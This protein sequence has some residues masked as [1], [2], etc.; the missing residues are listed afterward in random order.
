M[1][2][3][4]LSYW[5]SI[6]KPSFK[7]IF[8]RLFFILLNFSTFVFL[9]FC[10]ILKF[11]NV[12]I[13]QGN[14]LFQDILNIF[15]LFFYIKGGGWLGSEPIV[16]NSTIFCRRQPT[17][18]LLFHSV[19]HSLTQS[20][21]F[22]SASPAYLFLFSCQVQSSQVKSSQVKSSQVWSSQVQSSP[23]K[24]SQVQS[25]Q[26]QS[27]QVKSSQVKSSQVKSST[28]K[29]SQVYSGLVKSTKIQ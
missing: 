12:S 25:S 9:H 23:V 26:V 28:F 5:L 3:K 2:G 8:F 14:F 6:P 27:I 15:C 13:R 7:S 21:F 16:E 24:S 1:I 22:K 18:Q 4:T 11:N 10:I 20:R 17:Q 29:S 19:S